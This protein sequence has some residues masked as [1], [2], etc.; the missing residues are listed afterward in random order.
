LICELGKGG[1]R[2]KN[3][4]LNNTVSFFTFHQ[5]TVKSKDECLLAITHLLLSE[6]KVLLNDDIVCLTTVKNKAIFFSTLPQTIS[7]L[8]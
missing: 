8:S 7:F 2:I 3:D 4:F 5:Q 1:F 6:K